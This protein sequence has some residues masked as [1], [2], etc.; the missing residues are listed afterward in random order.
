MHYLVKIWKILQGQALESEKQRFLDK[1]IRP[2]KKMDEYDLMQKI[3]IEIEHI[4]V[5][6]IQDI[7]EGWEEFLKKSNS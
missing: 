6:K 3:W 5:I 7:E 2:N 4:S 1:F